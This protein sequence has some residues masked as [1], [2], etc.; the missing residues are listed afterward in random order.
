MQRRAFLAA[1]PLALALTWPTGEAAAGTA[2]ESRPVTTQRLKSAAELAERTRKALEAGQQQVYLLGRIGQDLSEHGVT[3]SHLGFAAK[4][5]DGSW[6][7]YHELNECGTQHSRLYAQGLLEFFSDDLFQVPGGGID[8]ATRR[9]DPTARTLSWSG[10]A[11]VPRAALQHG[12]ISVLD[13]VPELESMGAGD[14]G[15]DRIGAAHPDSR[16]RTG[17]AAKQW[18]RAD[19]AGAAGDAAAGRADVQGKRGVRRPPGGVAVHEPGSND[20]GRFGAGVREE[21]VAEG[22]T[23]GGCL[24]HYQQSRFSC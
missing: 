8:L 4:E 15:R 11:R 16:P 7:V 2:C 12:G 3:W 6:T 10:G 9:P 21:A 17:L 5:E 22:E 24:T 14:A 1:L 23:G 20:D 18:L 13:A 19:A